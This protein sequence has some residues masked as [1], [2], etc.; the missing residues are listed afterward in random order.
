MDDTIN[1]REDGATSMASTE[2][3][4]KY[5]IKVKI[6]DGNA[7]GILGQVS[8]ALRDAGV[9]K[10]ERDQYLAEAQS[11]DYDNL[12]RVSIKWVNLR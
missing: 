2:Q 10:D 11:G 12:L 6:N 8:S 3:F 7:F 5:D 9:S 1:N 4:P